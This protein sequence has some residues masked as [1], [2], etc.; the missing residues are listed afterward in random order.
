M[1]A[2][3]ARADAQA[4]RSWRALPAPVLA[5]V[6]PQRRRA[7]F[8]PAT[9]ENER[10]SG[11]GALGYAT[12]IGSKQRGRTFGIITTT[13]MCTRSNCRMRLRGREQ[14]PRV[15]QGI[16]GYHAHRNEPCQNHRPHQIKR[17]R[18]V[19]SRAHKCI[20]PDNLWSPTHV[21]CNCSTGS[22]CG[23]NRPAHLGSGQLVHGGC[24]G[25]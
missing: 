12:N 2:D 8:A 14:G 5:R 25:R 9:R 3:S 4:L 10:G 21:C 16:S 11:V 15:S 19:Q 23:S 17:V 1:R 13:C 6:R 22:R 18:D 24:A 7:T 20:W